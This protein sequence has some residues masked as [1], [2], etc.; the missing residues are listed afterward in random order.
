MKRFLFTAAAALAAIVLPSPTQAQYFDQC[1]LMTGYY[2]GLQAGANFHHLSHGRHC[3]VSTDT[4]YLV[5][6]SIG[7]KTCYDVRLEGEIGYRRNCLDKVKIH[8]SK[9]RHDQKVGG[10]AS[11]LSYMANAIYDI[12]VCY[13]VK[14]YVGAGIGYARNRV[15]TYV[16]HDKQKIKAT[17]HKNG[18]AWQAIAGL[19][20]PL[21]G[22]SCCGLDKVDATLEY[23][24]FKPNVKHCYDQSVAVGLVTAL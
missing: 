8:Y 2:A 24:Y 5:N 9:F 20:Y 7:V 21:Q 1:D 13:F 10:H 6:G 11:S 16:T 14:P 4:G 23:R 12:P 17:H 18:F 3:K 15:S 19:A 22:F